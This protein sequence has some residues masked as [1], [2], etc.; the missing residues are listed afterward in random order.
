MIRIVALASLLLLSALAIY[1]T[2]SLYQFDVAKPNFELAQLPYEI[3][4]WN[5]TDVK[6]QD[7]TVRVLN[8]DSYISRIYRDDL[9]HEVSLHAA[10][11]ATPDEV[12]EAAPH[13]PRVCY[14][15][16]GWE[17]MNHSDAILDEDAARDPIE[18]CLFQKAGTQVITGHW[19]QMGN[20]RFTSTADGRR[21]LYGLMGKDVWP[22]TLKVLIQANGNSIDQGAEA[23][24]PFAQHLSKA[25]SE[26]SEEPK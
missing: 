21:V 26:L 13:H 5:G 7:D 24:L 16:A 23:I 11:W 10:I 6:M 22:A 15:A 20:Q 3:D 1:Y 8:A 2:E 17:T 9:G 18:L 19:Y 12:G 4:G 25:L 14:T